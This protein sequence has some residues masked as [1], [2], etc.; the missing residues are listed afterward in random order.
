MNKHQ[1]YDWLLFKIKRDVKIIF[2]IFQSHMAVLPSHEVGKKA[3]VEGI[4]FKIT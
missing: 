2:I 1:W 3:T 4:C